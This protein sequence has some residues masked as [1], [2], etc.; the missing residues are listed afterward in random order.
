MKKS[1][2][3]IIGAGNIGTKIA[4]FVLKQ[5]NNY[6]LSG[7]F[8]VNKIALDKFCKKFKVKSSPDID[9]L[10]KTSDLII[11]SASP[12]AVSEILKRKRIL[13]GKK[14]IIVSVGGL[15]GVRKIAEIT[16]KYSFDLYIPSG[17]VCGIDGISAIALGK[18]KKCD[19]VTLKPPAGFFGNDYLKKNKI[20]LNN[21]KKEKV[22]FKGSVIQAIKHFPKNINIAATVYL[23]LNF[24]KDV[25]VVIKASPF[26]K[27]NVHTLSLRSDIANINISIENIPSEDNPKTSAL[28]VSSV[29]ALFLKM[30]SSL[31]VGV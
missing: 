8:D 14:I 31:H 9:H 21:L 18:I 13:K 3:A 1:R 10:I 20:S 26:V 11:E 24:K 4:E 25:K 16:K 5:F 28:T 2:L 23:A 27:R 30:H 15:V 29:K 12:Q 19:I 6:K 7:V 22:I 17:A